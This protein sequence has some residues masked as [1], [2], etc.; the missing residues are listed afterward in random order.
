MR[1]FVDIYTRGLTADEFQRVFTRDT[2]DAWRYFA[3]A[4]D[5]NALRAVVWYKRPVVLAHAFFLAFTLKLTPARRALFAIA[6][7]TAVIGLLELLRGFR[8]AWI[9]IDP[10]VLRFPLLMP[11]WPAGTGWLITALLL[12]NLLVLL[13]VFE[14]LSLKSDLEIARDIQLAMLPRGVYLRDG[15]EAFGVTRPANTVGGD[16]YDIQP[17]RDGRLLV[18]LGDVA[19]KGS[20]AALLMAL[21]L[22]ML[23]TLLDENLEET[24]LA[25]RLNVQIGRHAPV[26][27]FITLLL[28]TI[29]PESGEVTSVN[30]GH[31]PGL[32]CRTSGEFDRL[33][34]GGIA[35][36]MF[37]GS[38][39]TAE[40]ARLNPGDL[41]VA[42]SDGITEAE[43]P[44]GVPF[45]E[46][47]LQAQIRAHAAAPLQDIGKAVF[48]AVEQHARDVRFADDL[49]ILL[50]RRPVPVSPAAEIGD[51]TPMPAEG[52][53]DEGP[54]RV[55]AESNRTGIGAGSG[56]TGP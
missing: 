56:V 43:N 30:A 19:G 40:R 2:R 34:V 55:R 54:E 38:T 20:P 13:E 25:A 50:I 16:F 51:G 27:R 1:E 49:S 5:R 28:M 31:L 32:I 41:L 9:P 45:D 11:R 7:L 48:T 52:G 18:A 46:A 26:S 47:G 15:V 33:S 6:L 4:I 53:A 35:L 3:R 36:G 23:R 10:V 21:L 29:D 42:Y 12:L 24:A 22:A 17:L 8:V 14:R 39:Y 44:S 37:E